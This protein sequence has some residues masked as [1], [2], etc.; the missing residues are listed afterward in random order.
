MTA[1]GQEF[2]TGQV[3]LV[4]GVYRFVRHA[5]ATICYVTPAQREIPLSRGE[6]FPPLAGCHHSVVWALVRPA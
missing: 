6:R 2:T 3:C 1:I 5:G 4:S